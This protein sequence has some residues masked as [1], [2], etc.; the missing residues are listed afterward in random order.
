[1]P[2]LNQVVLAGH[3]AGVPELR[4][5]TTGGTAVCQFSVATNETYEQNGQ[6]KEIVTFVDV[7]AWAGMAEKASKYTKGQAVYVVG[8]LR[9]DSW[10]DKQTNQKRY[11]L[12]VVADVV[13]S[14]F[15]GEAKPKAPVPASSELPL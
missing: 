6:Q 11:K 5:T 13:T 12:Y 2:N 14:A 8:K 4:Y 9:K 3:L 7:T 10:E 15:A 1:M